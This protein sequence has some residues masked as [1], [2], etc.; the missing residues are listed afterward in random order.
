MYKHKVYNIVKKKFEFT[1]D[2]QHEKQVYEE[3]QIKGFTHIRMYVS[4]YVSFNDDLKYITMHYYDKD[5][6]SYIEVNGLL[7]T[8]SC[9]NM[10]FKINLGIFY[11]HSKG[12]IYG[13]LKLE[14]VCL[15]NNDI[16]HPVIVDLGSCSKTKPTV[17]LQT[18][19]PEALLN[20]TL[21]YK[22][23]I[24]TLG[25]LYMECITTCTTKYDNVLKKI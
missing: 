17:S 14:N 11:I 18:A 9:R 22:H 21:N 8:S 10:C 1:K 15:K 20:Q 4:N 25:V 13:D 23:D 7:D 16:N 19:S 24:W 3:L 2:Y 12:Y 6:F 5:L